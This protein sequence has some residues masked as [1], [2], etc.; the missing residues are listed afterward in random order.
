MFK[1]AWHIV[2]SVGA[3]VTIQGLIFTII[4]H[5]YFSM[6][7]TLLGLL[8]V[9]GGLHV[10]TLAAARQA[11][12]NLA[13]LFERVRTSLRER[14]ARRDEQRELKRQ[15]DEE[16][17]RIEESL[18]VLERQT[19]RAPR[20]K[21]RPAPEYNDRRTVVIVN[22]APIMLWNPGIA[23]ILSLIVP[24]LG[25]LYK[26]QPLNAIVWFVFVGLGYIALIV[27]GLILHFCCVLGA[28]SGNPILRR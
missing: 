4:E 27:P 28:L 12:G 9:A 1:S 20:P 23:A 13:S 22:E 26:R 8:I 15:Q 18:P 7:F 25:Q 11:K 14:A 21:P 2:A 3:L 16:N 24:G 5:N 10:E 17:A 6:A 19:T